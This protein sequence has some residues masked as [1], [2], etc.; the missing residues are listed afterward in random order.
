MRRVIPNILED[1]QSVTEGF[2]AGQL[3]GADLLGRALG[4]E[5]QANGGYVTGIMVAA[6]P[7][8][9]QF[10]ATQQC[11]VRAGVSDILRGA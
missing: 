8:M 7:A 4:H 6:V 3:Y 10:S 9:L 1:I 5:I 11:I 2:A